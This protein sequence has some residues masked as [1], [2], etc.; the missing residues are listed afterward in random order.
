MKSLL[1]VAA[2]ALLYSLPSYAQ[3]G[4]AKKP[5]MNIRQYWFVMLVKGPNRNQDS[6]TAAKIQAGHM[7]NMD[8]LY[9]EGKLKV[10]GPF[11][12]SGDWQGLFI[13]DCPTKQEVEQLLQTDPA[14]SSGR[15]NYIIKSWWTEPS[16]SFTPG[17][18]KKD[19]G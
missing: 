19:K 17:I 7:S 2:A 18:P 15:L 12:E 16:G 11:G 14:I 8:K 10:A 1:I 13:F 4:S 3:D 5:P 6:A 9:F